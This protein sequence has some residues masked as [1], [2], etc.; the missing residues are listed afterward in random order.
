MGSQDLS[1]DWGRP[2]DPFRSV[3]CPF[4]VIKITITTTTTTALSFGGEVGE[5][6]S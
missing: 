4:A 5:G 6:E 2:R 1:S 3:M